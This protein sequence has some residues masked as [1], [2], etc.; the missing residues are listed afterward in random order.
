[1][2]RRRGRSEQTHRVGAELP[3]LF[4][5]AVRFGCALVQAQHELQILIRFLLVRQRP[6]V[7][8]FG[9]P[10]VA[11]QRA[12]MGGH[13]PAGR[14]SGAGGTQQEEEAGQDADSQ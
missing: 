6:V 1:M 7:R 5:P 3:V 14:Y 11:L 12:V 9:T 4:G 8:A 10:A 2:H 13:L